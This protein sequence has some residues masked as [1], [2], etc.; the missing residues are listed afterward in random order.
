LPNVKNDKIGVARVL[1]NLLSNAFKF[2]RK[3]GRVTVR[4]SFVHDELHLEVEDTG[5]GIEPSDVQKIFERFSRLDQHN[6]I[7]GTGLGLFVVK[8]IVNAHGGK[9]DVTSKPGEGTKFDI[10][11]PARPPVN[12]RGELISLDFA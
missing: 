6:E 7:A 3:G 12:E 5:S 11:L 8:S 1:G 9:I 2:T 4:L 10:A